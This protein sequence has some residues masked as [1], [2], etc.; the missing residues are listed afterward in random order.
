MGYNVWDWE[1]TENVIDFASWGVKLNVR[2][3]ANPFKLKVVPSLWIDKHETEDTMKYLS[4]STRNV[5]SEATSFFHCVYDSTQSDTWRNM[6]EAT[7][8]AFGERDLTNW[9]RK[10][11]P[12][13]KREENIISKNFCWNEDN[14]RTEENLHPLKIHQAIFFLIPQHRR[15]SGQIRYFESFAQ[16]LVR[17]GRTEW[18]PSRWNEHRT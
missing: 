7:P 9:W 10:I 13:K 5:W 11:I 12:L 18:H 2:T 15:F 17:W 4:T 6:W 16:D 1:F 8:N 14:F 3:S